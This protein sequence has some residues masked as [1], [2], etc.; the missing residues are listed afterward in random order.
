[1]CVSN[2]IKPIKPFPANQCVSS[3]EKDLQ[4]SRE[5]KFPCREFYSTADDAQ[6]ELFSAIGTLTP[7]TRYSAGRRESTVFSETRL[8]STRPTNI[9]VATFLGPISAN[10]FALQ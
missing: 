9:P 6:V 2:L 4:S 8:F 1:M 10:T 3:E 5:L 7:Q